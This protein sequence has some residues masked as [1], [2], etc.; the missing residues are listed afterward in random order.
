MKDDKI[1]VCILANIASPF[2]GGNFIASLF[3]LEEKLKINND[4]KM[5][6]VFYSDT[7]CC[8]WAKKM[9]QDNKIVYF[10]TN[11]KIKKI[12]QLRRILQDNDIN[13]L[14]LHYTFPIFLLIGLR[15]FFIKNLLIIA[16]NHMHVS[17]SHENSAIKNFKK[18][19]KVI[20]YNNTIDIVCAV[21]EA[22]YYDLLNW[23]IYNEKCRYIDNGIVFSRLDIKCENGKELYNIPDKK[24]LMIYGTAFYR[25]GV[26]ISIHAIKEIVDQYNILLMIVCENEKFV[27]GEIKK[28]FN[29]IPDWILIVPPLDN[30]VFYFKMS[31]I[32]LTPSREEAFSYA[33]LEAIYCGTPVIRSDYPGMNRKL[34]HDLVVPVNDILALRQNI[35]SLLNQSELDKQ[36]ILAEQKKYIIQRWNIDVWSNN[37]MNMYFEH[38]YKQ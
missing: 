16:H 4:S 34:P 6:Y 5:I 29:H 7:S 35:I 8:N 12:L 38:S 24:V 3:D 21:S 10:L 11:K 37:I 17:H 14:H 13:V 25:K 32:Y 18:N 30:I 22:V 36:N 31:D 19:I 33:M 2:G 28:I 1:N 23:G 20:L 9:I 27:S 26:D 15:F